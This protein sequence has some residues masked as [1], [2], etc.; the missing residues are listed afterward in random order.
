ME[1]ARAVQEGARDPFYKPMGQAAGGPHV[2]PPDDPQSRSSHPRS[3]TEGKASSAPVR[4]RA[5]DGL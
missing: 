1:G 3:T 2:Q 4:C 5:G